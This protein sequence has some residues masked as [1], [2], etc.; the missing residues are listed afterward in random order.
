MPRSLAIAIAAILVAVVGATPAAAH[1]Y[2]AG[3]TQP[4]FT[5]RPYSYNSSW[6]GPMDR[7]LSNWNATPTPAYISKS[8]GSSSSVV[9]T[10]YSDTWYGLY[11]S[12][13]S[14]FQIKLNSRT[15]SGDASNFS[16]FVTSVFVHELGHGLSLAHNDLTS[17]MNHGRNRNT[18]TTPQAHDNSDVNSY[19]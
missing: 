1:W 11:S 8:S 7:S 18:L 14:Y 2:G 15:I 4:N 5:I 6:Q 17:I 10:S 3:M 13:G 12:Y 9:A 19:Y 16:N